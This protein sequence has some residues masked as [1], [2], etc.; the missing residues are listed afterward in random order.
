MG[1]FD[2][3]NTT[4][5]KM[6]GFVQGFYKD[7]LKD[8]SKYYKKDKPGYYTGST[9]TPFSDVTK[10]AF[11]GMTGLADANS[12]TNGMAPHLQS[13]LDNGGF[14]TDQMNTMR[15]MRD[16]INTPWMSDMI[17]GD[18]L[19]TD[20]R[21]VADFYRGDMNEA[22]DPNTIPGYS[23]VRSRTLDAGANAV[24]GQAAKMG[25][26]GGAANQGILARTQMDTAA[27][28]DTAEYDKWRG[29]RTAGAGGLAGISQQGVDN[30][31]GAT[32]LKSGMQGQLFN[33]EASGLDRMG[34]AYQTA[35]QPY[36]TKRAVGAEYEDLFSREKQDELRKF[37]AANPMN[38]FKDYLSLVN[39]VP[40]G[41]TT[42][43]SPS[44]AQ[45]LGAG[46]LTALSLPTMMGWGKPAAGGTVA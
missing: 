11:S 14:T 37:D 45:L 32:A 20:Q 36:Q 23:Q 19:T 33:A 8:A 5:P 44:L 1:L 39:G 25:R 15:G 18:G 29:R 46:G 13:I 7:I 43:T 30:R 10:D 31:S 6:P 17:N 35:L 12:G 34:Q 28:M 22:F 3:T 38:K 21:S 16:T 2:S 4:K 40:T 24:A 42:T 26:L 9:V 27:G 41:Q